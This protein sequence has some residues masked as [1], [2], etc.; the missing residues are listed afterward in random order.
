MT[1]LVQTSKLLPSRTALRIP[2]GMDIRYTNNVVHKPSDIDTG[3]LSST[4]S[5][6]F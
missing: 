4:R 5:M 6:T 1:A 2:N 3:I